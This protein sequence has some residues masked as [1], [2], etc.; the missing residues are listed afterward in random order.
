MTQ[1]TNQSKPRYEFKY[2]VEARTLAT[3]RSEFA[4]VMRP[5]P[6]AIDGGYQV[7]SLYFD[8]SD[9]AAYFEK[10]DGIDHRYKIRLR[11]YGQVASP[12][13]L[14]SVTTYLEAK[15][16]YNALIHKNRVPVS[17]ALAETLIEGQLLST[18]ILDDVDESHRE[19][20][21][22]LDHLIR[23]QPLQPFVTVSYHREPLV[24]RI[25]PS[26]R[27]TIDTSLCASGP[28][29]FPR[30]DAANARPVLPSDLAVLEIK[31]HWAMPLWLLE[32]CRAQHLDLR[33]YSKY[34]SGMERLYPYLARRN[35]RLRSA[36]G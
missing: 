10:L 29:S 23:R 5:D 25:D 35:V 16:R 9:C 7:T 20:A 32:I 6:H 12:G 13:D 36:S 30:F 33:R 27:I 3:L 22:V 17:T 34:C 28:A 31:F 1:P 4:D 26:L 24:C 18:H 21:A 2:V 14:G 8:S 19:S 15:H 11:Y